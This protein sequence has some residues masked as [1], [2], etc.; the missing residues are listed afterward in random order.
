MIIE[1][2][3]VY[4]RRF[5]STFD[6]PIF[7]TV[8]DQAG[9]GQHALHFVQSNTKVMN[10]TRH[11][12]NQ[13]ASLRFPS[14]RLIHTDAVD[15]DAPVGTLRRSKT[16]SPYASP[17]VHVTQRRICSFRSMWISDEI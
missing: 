9:P 17:E 14:L 10:S 5:A 2:I 16:L 15:V 6:F 13:A 4:L 12:E 7:T 11:H 1:S 3:S 8:D